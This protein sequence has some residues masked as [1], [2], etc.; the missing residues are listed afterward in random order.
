MSVKLYNQGKEDAKEKSSLF[1]VL[2][3][4]GLVVL[5]L[6]MG[7]SAQVPPETDLSINIRS[8]SVRVGDDDRAYL[9]LKVG[10]RNDGPDDM[11]FNQIVVIDYPY[12]ISAQFN[13]PPQPCNFE[14]DLQ[15][16]LSTSAF[17]PALQ[18][19]EEYQCDFLI[20]VNQLSQVEDFLLWIFTSEIP[21]HSIQI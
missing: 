12:S 13:M 15:T 3:A 5:M 9:T 18:A 6:S 7:V 20:I 16:N 8:L 2:Y 10:M 4:C 19:G 14:T 1:C 21:R 11:V 17:F